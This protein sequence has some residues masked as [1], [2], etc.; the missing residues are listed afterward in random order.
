[1]KKIL[2][3]AIILA[4]TLISAQETIN[5]SFGPGYS[6]EVYYK[7][8]TQN[9]TIFPAASWD[10]AF[11]RNS[12]F[13][14][15][16]RVNDGIGIKVYEVGDMP[17]EY[18]TVDVTDQS[19]WINLVNSDENW[20]GGAF[21]SGSATYGFGEYNPAT[22]TV[23]G[24]IIFVLEYADGTFRK[25]FIEDYFGAYTFKYATWDG[26]AWSGNTIA[27]VENTS[28]PD[29]IYNYYS[30]QNNEE[31]VAEPAEG[32]WDFVF[33]RYNTF[34][35]PP[36]QNYIVSG[37][38]QN[39]NVTIAQNEETGDPDPNSLTYSDNINTIGYDW[40][41]FEG[42][43]QIFSDQKYYIKYADDRVYRIYFTDFEGQSTGNLTFVLEDVSS[44]GFESVSA[45]LAFGIY[46]NP[47]INGEVSIIY[48]NTTATSENN[49]IRIFSMNGLEVYS[50]KAKNDVGLFNKTI[51]ISSLK[52]GIYI[53]N[54]QS[55][56]SVSSKKLI[57]K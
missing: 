32:D 17:S 28:N 14:L 6:N 48:E 45:N 47:S 18:E 9:E 4:S 16:V 20:E 5:I 10:M 55:G 19:N 29:N 23:E 1:M 50:A 3:L 7:L 33:R 51:N 30:L 31:V 49:N 44:L 43:W 12:N 21:M 39:P 15:S 53:V 34:L 52:S 36:G 24:T 54:F 35:D 42:T 46:P 38:L 26:T 25:L 40:K 2:Q 11:L 8:D 56:K 41:S 37:V 22:N 13:N 27:T 57:I